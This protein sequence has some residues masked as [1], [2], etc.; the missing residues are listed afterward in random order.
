MVNI[1]HH[2]FYI[3]LIFQLFLHLCIG[4]FFFRAESVG[5][6]WEYV[7]GIQQFGTLRASY[8]FFTLPKMWPTNLFIIIMLV[9]E[10]L[11]RDKQHALQL[12][13]NR[14]FGRKTIRWTM[15]VIIYLLILFNTGKSQTFLYFQ[16]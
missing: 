1:L 5:Q 11:Q 3:L 15:Y 6:A 14:F 16:F 10:W 9:I 12:P 13:N 2:F 8:R 4:L 7:C